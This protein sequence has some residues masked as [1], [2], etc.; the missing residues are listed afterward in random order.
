MPEPSSVTLGPADLALTYRSSV[1]DTDQPFRLY[2]PE[3]YDGEKPMPML[4]VLHGTSG[5]QDSYFDTAA[6]GDGLYKR[7]ADKHG[8]IVVSPHGRGVTEYHGIGEHDVLSV[9]DHVKQHFAVDEDRVVMSGLS[10]GGTGTSYLC[11][12]YPDQFAGGVAIGSCYKDLALLPNFRHVPM[13]FLQGQYDW[14]LYGKEGP[15]PGSVRLKELGYDAVLEMV[16]KS[17][18]NAVPLTGDRIFEWT[19]EQRRVR[20]PEH[21]SLRAYFPIHGKAYWVEVREIA[22]IGRPASVEARVIDRRTI[23]IDIENGACIA[24][25]PDPA[26]LDLESPVEVRANG[27]GLGQV[28]CS[29][30]Q[31]IRLTAVGDGWQV[32]TATR[33]ARQPLDY[34][35]HRIGKVIT[36]PTQEGPVETTMGTWMA[37]AMRHATDADVA[38]CN[39]RYQRGIPL[40]DGQDLHLVDL[41]NWIRPCIWALCTCDITGRALLE[42]VEDS[43]YDGRKRLQFLP[44]VSGCSYTFDGSRPRGNR[45]PETDIDPD[46]VY[47]VVFEKQALSRETLHL[48]GYFEQIDFVEH[49]ITIISAAWAYV[50]KCGGV[51][52][53]RLEGRVREVSAF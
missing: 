48:A 22:R 31:E 19:V 1:D 11:G 45:I 49:D 12:L 52:D 40:E 46:R 25:F 16:P 6:Y 14:P 32:G 18:H 15:F 7:L 44:Q 2:L 28:T 42:I 30:E 8:V 37:N 3:G 10:M 29:S 53:A 35:T 50:E 43:I 41:V 5:D 33:N 20:H 17:P 4:V 38:I 36:A 47:R 26:L 23:D 34:R 51:I 27:K 39:G 21:V 13:L 24:L 9:I